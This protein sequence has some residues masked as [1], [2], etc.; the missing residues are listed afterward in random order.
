MDVASQKQRLLA[1]RAEITGD[2]LEIEDQ[3]DDPPT[4]DWED[5][6]AERQGDDVLQALGNL[7]L[8]ELRQIDAALDRIEKVT[9]GI[10]AK[11]GGQI[12]DARLELLPATPLCKKCAV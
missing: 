10:C 3:L 9:Y 1:R 5:R 12:S 7:E 11:C 2:L 4:K 8:D 6:S